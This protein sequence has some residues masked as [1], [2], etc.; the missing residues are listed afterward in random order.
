M[1]KKLLIIVSGG[2]SDYITDD[3]DIEV[4]IFDEDNWE[5]MSEDERNIVRSDYD[6]NPEWKEFLPEWIKQVIWG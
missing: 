3:N 4:D 6:N 2:V 1:S 5:A